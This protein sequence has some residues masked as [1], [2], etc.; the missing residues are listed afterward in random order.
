MRGRRANSHF[1]SPAWASLAMTYPFGRCKTMVAGEQLHF[2]PPLINFAG[3]INSPPRRAPHPTAAKTNGLC[4]RECV[5]PS[6]RSRPESCEL[7]LKGKHS[8]KTIY[9]C[10]SFPTQT[11]INCLCEY[12]SP[13]YHARKII[14]CNKRGAPRIF[15][16]FLY[17]AI[18][19]ELYHENFKIKKPIKLDNKFFTLFS[20]IFAINLTLN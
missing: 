8:P 5:R 10:E 12:V 6:S 2:Q 11:I 20:S 17:K 15:T 14:G 3:T 4:K 13:V 9:V 16:Y 19:T 18:K 7:H 1:G